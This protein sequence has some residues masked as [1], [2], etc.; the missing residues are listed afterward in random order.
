MTLRQAEVC[1][2]T[3]LELTKLLA[4]QAM[5]FGNQALRID[6]TLRQFPVRFPAMFAGKF[7][8]PELFG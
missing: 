1:A 5:T 4:R 7:Q 8:R 2:S 6:A 3:H